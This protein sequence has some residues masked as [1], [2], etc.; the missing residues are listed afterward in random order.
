MKI[1]KTERINSVLNLLYQKKKCINKKEPCVQ[2][3]VLTLSFFL[4]DVQNQC[5]K[6]KFYAIL[7]FLFFIGYGI[8]FTASRI[9]FNLGFL[10]NYKM[11]RKSSF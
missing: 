3:T 1:K 5:N 4:T 7:K 11:L 9:I 6:R 2:S 8:Q 10:L